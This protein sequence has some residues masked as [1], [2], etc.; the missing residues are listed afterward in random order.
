M[1]A[2]IGRKFNDGILIMADK[3]ITYRGT[4]E[5]YDNEKKIFVLNNRLL[6]AYAGV[7]NIIDMGLDQLISYSTSTDSLEDIINYS[8]KIFKS[9]LYFFEKSH[10]KQ[11]YDT[12]YVLA[13][14]NENSETFVFYF[15][16]D[17]DFQKKYP[18]EF[19]FKSF[20]NTEALNLRSYLTNQVDCSNNDINYYI[21][22]FS[23]AIR[24]ISNDND[25]VG[26]TAY[27]IFLSKKEIWEIDI[28]ENG[29]YTNLQFKENT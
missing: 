18:L 28:S 7:K 6:F 29:G 25:M 11:R 17:D 19:F 9:S 10:P 20:P 4:Q 21:Q 26:N 3:R 16:S 5:V 2:I 8:Q 12:V 24:K 23:S 27:S 22:K 13:G 1:T 15:S 14:F